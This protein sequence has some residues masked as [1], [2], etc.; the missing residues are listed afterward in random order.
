MI[1]H[2]SIV[3]SR[4]S[5]QFGSPQHDVGC[6]GCVVERGLDLVKTSDTGNCLDMDQLPTHLIVG[7]LRD[8]DPKSGRS[9]VLHPLPT[10]V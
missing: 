9:Q 3:K 5:P 7:D 1:R 10:L 4:R 2:V 6:D 8:E